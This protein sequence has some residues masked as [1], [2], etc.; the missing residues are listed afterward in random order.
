MTDSNSKNQTKQKKNNSSVKID[1][2]H[3][4]FV[5]AAIKNLPVA[6]DLFISSLPAAI[7]TKLDL[8]QL[9]VTSESHIDEN[10]KAFMSDIIFKCAY[11]D[12]KKIYQNPLTNRASIQPR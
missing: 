5:R 4:K 8:D 2:P 12:T 7:Q 3:D 6:K 11:K 10:L 1:N 9:E